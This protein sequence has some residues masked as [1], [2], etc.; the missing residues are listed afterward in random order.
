MSTSR[1]GREHVVSTLL[2][3]TNRRTNGEH[4]S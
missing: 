2:R 4:V 3:K 1:T